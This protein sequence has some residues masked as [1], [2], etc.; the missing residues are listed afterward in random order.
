MARWT[1][2][3]NYTL[4]TDQG[5]IVF[6]LAVDSEESDN[7]KEDS[8]DVALDN[9]FA[10]PIKDGPFDNTFLAFPWQNVYKIMILII[11]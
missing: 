4:Q 6:M 3:D 8:K 7:F 1:V 5:I 2:N 10:K 11:V 9:T